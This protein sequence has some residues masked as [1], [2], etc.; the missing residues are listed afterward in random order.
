MMEEIL[1]RNPKQVEEA[2]RRYIQKLDQMTKR[3]MP[4]R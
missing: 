4:N 1:R 3:K 2:W